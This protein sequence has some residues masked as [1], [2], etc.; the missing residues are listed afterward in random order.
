MVI[1]P[2]E[3]EDQA[4]VIELWR[5]CELLR[6]Q[7]DPVK[8]IARKL[9]VQREMFLVGVVDERIV[10]SVMASYDGHRC[11]VNYLAVN[12]D[13]QRRGF[14]RA[15][16]AEVERIVRDRGCPKINLQVR[17]SNTGVIAFYKS[18]GF[19]VDDVTSMGKR[20]EFDQ[21]GT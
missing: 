7:I 11:W 13:Q 18:I 3:I 8:D 2:F 4:A 10:A 9:K 5:R 14:G 15:I 1:R 17:T 16:M 20:L 21:P 19:A 12:P 6:P